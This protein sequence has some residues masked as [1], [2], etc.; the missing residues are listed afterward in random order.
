MT[1]MTRGEAERV[2]HR[3]MRAMGAPCEA[4][5]VMADDKWYM[6]TTGTGETPRAQF[7]YL[8]DDVD[9]WLRDP[10]REDS[11]E[12]FCAALIAEESVA[13][14]EQMRGQ[15]YLI[16]APGACQPIIRTRGDL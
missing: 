3:W 5:P 8:A 12:D 16:C 1:T 11:Y 14:A 10:L 4:Q 7:A 2:C 6:V 9:A 15:G 13:V